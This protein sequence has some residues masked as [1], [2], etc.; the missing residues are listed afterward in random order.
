MRSVVVAI[1]I[2]LVSTAALR[3]DEPY[4]EFVRGLR[5]RGMPDLAVDY[6]QRLS[7]NAPARLK[8][9]LPLEIAKARLDLVAAE[10][11]EKKR[12]KLFDE[13]RT[14]YDQFLKA[15]PPPPLA[16]DAAVDVARLVALQGKYLLAQ[17]R[18]AEDAP[19]TAGPDRACAAALR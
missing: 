5:Q 18:R 9:I 3:A 10:G 17:A 15:D 1:G 12:A 11:N 16:A 8:S 6:L 4:V 2:A 14:T 7:E 13:A 19:D